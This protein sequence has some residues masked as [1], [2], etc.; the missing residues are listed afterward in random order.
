M[1][2]EYECTRLKDVL[3]VWFLILA[4]MSIISSA[5]KAGRAFYEQVILKNDRPYKLRVTP[6][7][8]RPSEGFNHS[9]NYCSINKARVPQLPKVETV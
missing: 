4:P 7:M 3:I 9:G 5:A 8:F 1:S 2:N 6:D